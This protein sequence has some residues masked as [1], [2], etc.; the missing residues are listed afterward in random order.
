MIHEQS[1]R[2]TPALLAKSDL[3]SPPTTGRCRVALE[4]L[5]RAFNARRPLAILADRWAFDASY[6]IR[7]FLTGIEND[8][9]VVRIEK[10]SSDAIEG[11]R[12][13]IRATGFEP[14][15]MTLAKLENMFTK[16]LSFQR[17]RHR[18]TIFVIEGSQDNGGWVRDKVRRL[19]ALESENQFGLM[20][21]LFRQ[22]SRKSKINGQSRNEDMA[23]VAMDLANNVPK[24]LQLTPLVRESGD[25]VGSMS[26]EQDLTQHHNGNAP[27]KMILTR[28]G[29]TLRE[30]TMVQPRLMIGSAADNDLCINDSSISRY[31]VLLVRFG[32]TAF[33]KDL[34]SSSGTYV[35]MSRIQDQMVIHQDILSIGDHCIKFIAPG[36]R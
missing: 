16:F 31:H 26:V 29:K 6:I 35:N 30:L 23:P 2:V 36:V 1:A 12:E 22:S 7:Q 9:V 24:P 10:T 14:G 17:A 3:S 13:V 4:L 34:N 8:V 32:D 21:I 20:V 33:V 5:H 11:M 27:I 15:D 25:V 28:N 18:R 19:V